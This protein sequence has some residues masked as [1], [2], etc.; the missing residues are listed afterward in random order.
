MGPA[1]STYFHSIDIGIHDVQG[2]SQGCDTVT[3]HLDRHSESESESISFLSSMSTR[4][5]H[6]YQAPTGVS[7]AQCHC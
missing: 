7:A 6:K 5:L 1:I 4:K 2:M 3:G